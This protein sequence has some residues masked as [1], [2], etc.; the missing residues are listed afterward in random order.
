[1]ANKTKTYYVFGD[2]RGEED[3]EISTSGECPCWGYE[4]IGEFH[5][6]KEAEQCAARYEKM[7]AQ[8]AE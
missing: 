5:S 1:M 2:D 7:C 3:C 6:K 8:F 4:L